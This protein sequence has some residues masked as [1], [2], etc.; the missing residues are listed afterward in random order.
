MALGLAA[1][2]APAPAQEPYTFTVSLLGGFGGSLDE[3]DAGYGNSSLQ[4]GLGLVT[5]RRAHL[6]GRIGSI[7]LDGDRLGRLF[8]ASLDYVTVAGEY[9]FDEGIYESGVYAGIG[10]YRLEG[11]VAA[12]PGLPGLVAEDETAIGL[13][14]G[15]TGEVRLTRIFALQAELGGHYLLSDFAEFFVQA[16]AGVAVHF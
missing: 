4:L 13:A 1:A 11:L 10:G 5:E 3:N 2:A 6:V 9:R 16:L 7:D 8:D 15:A 14:F 12:P